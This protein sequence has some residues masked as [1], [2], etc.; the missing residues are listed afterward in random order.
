MELV[1]VF[2]AVV[3]RESNCCVCPPCVPT[4]GPKAADPHLVRRP[5][6]VPAPLPQSTLTLTGSS[7]L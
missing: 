3:S 1:G 2:S 6:R 7:C 4:G 5:Q